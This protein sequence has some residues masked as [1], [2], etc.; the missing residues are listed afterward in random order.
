VAPIA[1]PLT[2]LRL[3]GVY[4]GPRVIAA[5]VLGSDYA[6]TVG[7]RQH[8]GIGL[9]RRELNDH[10]REPFNFLGNEPRFLRPI[11]FKFEA[12]SDHA[13]IAFKHDGQPQLARRDA[14]R[15]PHDELGNID[16]NSGR[17]IEQMR[18]DE[19]PIIIGFW[20]NTQEAPE[21][22][23]RATLAGQHLTEI[24]MAHI[25]LKGECALAWKIAV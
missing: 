15:R 4:R 18:R 8:A 10:A 16:A 5:L 17:L 6:G 7:K 23:R 14:I 9:A 13:Q 20:K 1:G 22:F 2:V 21:D 11:S 12:L 24:R 25:K 19:Q 3:R